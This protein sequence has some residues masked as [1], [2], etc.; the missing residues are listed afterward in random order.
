MKNFT[1]LADNEA[2]SNS[3]LL[4]RFWWGLAANCQHYAQTRGR[5]IPA[6]SRMYVPLSGTSSVKVPFQSAPIETAYDVRLLLGL[7]TIP[8]QEVA[9]SWAADGV[10]NRFRVGPGTPEWGA[11]RPWFPV[12]QIAGPGQEAVGTAGLDLHLYLTDWVRVETTA[13]AGDRDL[14]ISWSPAFPG[15]PAWAPA[16]LMG[17]FAIGQATEADV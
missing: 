5:V 16:F 11:P 8:Q 10:S 12:P 17:V 2:F 14:V 4:S 3:P 7:P 9:W 15:Y 1:R 13:A 6:G